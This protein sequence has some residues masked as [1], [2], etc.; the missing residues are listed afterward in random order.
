MT[1]DTVGPATIGRLIQPMLNSEAL[2][3]ATMPDPPKVGK[4]PVSLQG[5]G[6]RSQGRGVRLQ[7]R[8]VRLQGSPA[9]PR[10][11][12]RRPRQVT[13]NIYSMKGSFNYVGAGGRLVFVGPSSQY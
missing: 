7:G 4:R 11:Q 1:E 6:V 10:S 8:G 3:V 9:C 5:R 12:R 2:L 13:G